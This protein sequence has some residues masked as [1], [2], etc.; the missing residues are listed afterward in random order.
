L[1]VVMKGFILLVLLFSSLAFAREVV[2]DPY[3]LGREESLKKEVDGCKDRYKGQHFSKNFECQDAVRE[4]FE[5]EMP[6]RGSAEYAAQ[7]YGGLTKEQG[8]AKIKELQ[9]MQQKARE[10][11]RWDDL[12]PGEV[13]AEDFLAEKWWIMEHVLGLDPQRTYI[14][15]N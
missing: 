4:K 12:Q 6:K 15:Y 3:S 1:W 14:R 9:A 11:V 10:Y 7:H 5:A 8:E 13:V 2:I